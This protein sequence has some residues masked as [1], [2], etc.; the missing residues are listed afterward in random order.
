MCDIL[1]IVVHG[2]AFVLSLNNVLLVFVKYIEFLLEY[3]T[4]FNRDRR[5]RTVTILGE[6]SIYLNIEQICSIA[7]T[8][9]PGL[10]DDIINAE[11][12]TLEALTC[13]LSTSVLY[14]ATFLVKNK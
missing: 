12:R 1:K 8:T 6:C 10:R 3:F 4:V 13:G 9:I 11:N 2:L 5:K 7:T 14:V